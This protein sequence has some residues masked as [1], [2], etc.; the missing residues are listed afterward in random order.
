VKIIG[1]TSHYVTK[2]LDAGPIIEQNT[3]HVSHL[4]SID[5]FI[6]E[7]KSK[8]YVQEALEPS[9]PDN[10]G[11]N[12]DGSDRGPS[13]NVYLRKGGFQIMTMCVSAFF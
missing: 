7:L 8:G 2:E 9:D 4:N 3:T 1:A 6:E 12:A 11:E 10:P 5:D 13:K